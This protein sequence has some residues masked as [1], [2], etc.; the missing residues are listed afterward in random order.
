M[1]LLPQEGEAVITGPLQYTGHEGRTP[2]DLLLGEV[3]AKDAFHE[4]VGIT[5]GDSPSTDRLGDLTVGGDQPRTH[6][7]HYVVDHANH[8]RYQCLEAWEECFLF[9]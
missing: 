6:G 3:Q 8:Y 1:A 4:P 9:W 2:V 5:G 7:V